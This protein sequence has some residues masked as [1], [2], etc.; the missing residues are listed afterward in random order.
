MHRVVPKPYPNKKKPRNLNDF[1]AFQ[2]G[3]QDL[4]SVSGVNTV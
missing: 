3:K 4:K 2:C 1:G